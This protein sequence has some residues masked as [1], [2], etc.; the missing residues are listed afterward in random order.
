MSDDEL[1]KK[2]SN[3]GCLSYNNGFK[4]GYLLGFKDGY[5]SGIVSGVLLS[6]ITVVLINR[7]KQS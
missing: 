3:Y 2:I 7:F 4:D 5:L 1:I 6:T